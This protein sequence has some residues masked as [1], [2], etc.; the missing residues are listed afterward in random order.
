MAGG[1]A[2]LNCGSGFKAFYRLTNTALGCWSIFSGGVPGAIRS[3]PT[4]FQVTFTRS[5]TADWDN[6]LASP[7]SSL[8]QVFP[9][10]C[11]HSQGL[12]VSPKISNR[13]PNINILSHDWT[14]HGH[15]CTYQVLGGNWSIMVFTPAVNVAQSGPSE[16]RGIDDLTHS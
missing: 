10:A 14:Q 2:G 5:F 12:S 11:T 13:S 16:I 3:N 8:S 1:G 15:R 9:T 4:C 6:L 7:A